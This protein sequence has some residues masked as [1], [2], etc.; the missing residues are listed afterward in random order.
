MFFW[1][2]PCQLG[3]EVRV[4]ALPMMPIIDQWII[5]RELSWRVSYYPAVVFMPCRV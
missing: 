4:R 2:L 5:V 1:A 3:V